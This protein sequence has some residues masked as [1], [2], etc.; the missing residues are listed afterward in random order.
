MFCEKNIIN[1]NMKTW[2]TCM[3]NERIDKN[4]C[5]YLLKL[6]KDDLFNIVYDV[7]DIINDESSIKNYMKRIHYYLKSM[8]DNNYQMIKKYKYSNHLKTCG[9]LYVIGFGIQSLQSKL[10]ASLIYNTFDLDMKN[11]G[12][13]LLKYLCETYFKDYE[14]P[15]LNSYVL[16]RESI[17]EE[18]KIDKR[19]IIIAMNCDKY[20]KTKNEFIKNIDREF[21]KIQQLIKEKNIF[22]VQSSSKDNPNGSILNIH[23]CILENNILQKGMEELKQK[24]YEINSLLFDGL[25]VYKNNDEKQLEDMLYILNKSSDE[26]NIKWVNKPHIRTIE[27][28]NDLIDNNPFHYDNVKIEFEKKHFL[29]KTPLSFGEEYYENDFKKI[30][31][32]NKANFKDLTSN[33]QIESDNFKNIHILEEWLK[34]SNKRVY[35]RIDFLPYPRKIESDVYNS[36]FGLIGDNLKGVDVEFNKIL[37]HLK[38][39]VDYDEKSYEYLISYLSHLIQKPGEL[40]RVAILFKSNEGVGKNLF[41]NKFAQYFLNNEYYLETQKLDQITGRFNLIPK[42]LLV[43]IDEVSGKDTFVK[44]EDIKSLI[45]QEVVNWEQKNKEAILIQNCARYIFFSNNDV[46]IKISLTD[47]RYV[48]F[49]CNNEYANNTEYFNELLNEL[50][51][52]DCMY[53]F[54]NFLKNKDITKFNLNDRP[55]TKFYDELKEVNIPILVNFISDKYYKSTEKTIK[56]RATELYSNFKQ[57]LETFHR[58]IDYTNTKFGRDIKKI[59]GIEKKR[60]N[61]C[62]I[63]TIDILMLNEYLEVNNFIEKLEYDDFNSDSDSLSV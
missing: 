48:C 52:K 25:A 56:I 16:N 5:D 1:N 27:I 38:I 18:Y 44:E 12:P 35:R 37:N 36:F 14:F 31:L 34:D 2:G 26:Y 7:N 59:K 49:S 51:D 20:V 40:P 19:D 42:K 54:Y 62:N 63:Y 60:T 41:F 10:R 3:I 24:K 6:N 58:T 46:P 32:Y 4:M 28:D 13:T 47:R 43:C 8:K 9:R 61:T 53:S 23:L 33:Y 21:K 50:D 45:T 57:Y 39:L 30:A 15:F 11:A 55:I 22:N 17:I 29:I